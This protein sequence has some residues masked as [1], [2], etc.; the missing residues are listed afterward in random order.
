MRA[1]RR[2][3]VQNQVLI[4]VRGAKRGRCMGFLFAACGRGTHLD[5]DSMQDSAMF[6]NE[7]D[8]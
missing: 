1:L 2:K 6:Q 8:K 3:M 4:L 7:I 5:G